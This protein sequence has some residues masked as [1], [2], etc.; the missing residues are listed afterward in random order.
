[1]E[2][3]VHYM[4]SN[5]TPEIFVLSACPLQ[6]AFGRLQ[7]FILT[8]RTSPPRTPGRYIIPTLLSVRRLYRCTYVLLLQI[9]PLT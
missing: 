8:K 3:V 1:M 9:C 2:K 7:I 4:G 6:E 5:D